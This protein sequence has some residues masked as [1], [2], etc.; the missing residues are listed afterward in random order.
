MKTFIQVV[1]ISGSMIEEALYGIEMNYVQES[2]EIS[3]N[4]ALNNA[5]FVKFLASG[6]RK[7][8]ILDGDKEE[9]FTV[10]IRC[11]IKQIKHLVDIKSM[12]CHTALIVCPT[13]RTAEQILIYCVN[14][15]LCSPAFL[16]AL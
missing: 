3:L 1:T 4:Y 6:D 13:N 2:H 9:G 15:D 12:E 7:G 16:K 14:P 11:D 8:I 5:S 10:T